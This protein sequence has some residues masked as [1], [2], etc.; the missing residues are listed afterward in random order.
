MKHHLSLGPSSADETPF[1]LWSED[2]PEDEFVSILKGEKGDY[3]RHL[4]MGRLL[5]EGRL[6]DVW[7]YL[8]VHD[9]QS[10]W[11]GIR[12]HLG[13]R[14]LFWEYLL[15]TWRSHGLI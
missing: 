13:K 5:R 15:N 7:R 11:Q 14:R 6:A 4:Y 1:F 12:P 9:I 8:D 3:L 10:Q 2:I